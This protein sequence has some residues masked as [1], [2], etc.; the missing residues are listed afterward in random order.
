M[1]QKLNSPAMKWAY[2]HVAMSGL[3]P[4][5]RLRRHPHTQLERMMRSIT[6]FGIPVPIIIDASNEV[7]DGHLVFKAAKKLGLDEV[8]VARSD[9]LTPD[10]ARALRIV[11]NRL[12]ELGEWD[13]ELLAL[14]LAEIGKL[15][16]NI[17]LTG[18]SMP[19]IDALFLSSVQA[20]ESPGLTASTH[21]RTSHADA[22]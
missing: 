17:E 19:E 14:E 22:M 11:L 4:G 18:F 13:D 9:E 12:A 10:Q 21:W 6:E 2:S 20:D 1:A 5:P 7:I 15:S 3:T 16:L 8:P